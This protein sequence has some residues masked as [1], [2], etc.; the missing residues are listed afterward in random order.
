[1]ISCGDIDNQLND[2]GSLFIYVSYLPTSVDL[3]ALG[4][5]FA[6]VLVNRGGGGPEIFQ[7]NHFVISLS[8]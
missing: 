5:D 1:M 2:I 4:L 8:A 6:G 7:S 3:I